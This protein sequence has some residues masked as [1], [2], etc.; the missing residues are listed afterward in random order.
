MKVAFQ[1]EPGSYSHIAVKHLF[2]GVE[3]VGHETFDE[4]C[5]DLVENRVDFAVLP[6]ENSTHG[7]VYQ[8]YDNISDYDL[9]IVGEVYVRINFHL[10]AH[11][12]V[13]FSEITELYTH[14]VGLNQIKSFQKENPQIKFF[15][16]P[17]TAGSVAMIKKKGLKHAA[18]AASRLSANIYEMNILKENIHENPK[19]YTRFFVLTTIS[20]SDYENKK[21][22]K[23]KTTI[24]FVLGEEP[25]SLYKSLRCFADRDISLS[26]IESRPILNTDWEY[27]FYIDV[28]SG[29][30]NEKTQLA[31]KELQDYVR[32]LKIL[33][34]YNKG[35][36]IDS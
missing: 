21:G 1:G 14:P 4:V 35:E 29:Y 16:Y 10:I 33:G 12:G 18:A 8:N 19:N 15:E 34:T 27:R 31:I 13:K 5:K 28:E 26:K 25:G 23:R 9:R 17:D 7:S 20:N 2:N 3:Y 32:E 22:D 6:I 24:Q 11:K 30:E 36:Y